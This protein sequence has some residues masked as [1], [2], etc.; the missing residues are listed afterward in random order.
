VAEIC[1]VFKCG[2]P[3]V[4]RGFCSPCYRRLYQIEFTSRTQ[5]KIFRHRLTSVNPEK[6]TGNCLA[7]GEIKIYRRKNRKPEWSEGW[8]CGRQSLIH[9]QIQGHRKRARRRQML[10][11]F[12][13]ICQSVED[14]TYDH[15]HSTLEFRGTL[16]NPC[17]RGLGHFRDNPQLILKAYRYLLYKKGKT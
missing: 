15:D 14:L 4:S 17:N 3:V 2:K 7:C 8:R 9:A 1:A 6:R 11:K 12:C 16:C 13:D 5:T 10:S